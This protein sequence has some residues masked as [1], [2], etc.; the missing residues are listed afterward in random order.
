MLNSNH[1]I[2]KVDGVWIVGKIWN[3]NLYYPNPVAPDGTVQILT[4]TGFDILIYYY[5]N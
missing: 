2:T 3:N 1:F 4:D 5:R